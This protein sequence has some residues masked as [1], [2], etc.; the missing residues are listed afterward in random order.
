MVMRFH[1]KNNLETISMKSRSL[2]LG[3]PNVVK[4]PKPQ[5]VTN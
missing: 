5:S 4:I 1:R 2:T 3:T